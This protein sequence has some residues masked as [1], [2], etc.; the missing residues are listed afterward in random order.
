MASWYGP[1]LRGND[2]ASGERFRPHRRT[3]AHPSLPFDTVVVVARVD[4]GERV[5]VRIN[6]RGPYVEGRIIDL[7]KGAARRL[8]MLDD[9]VVRVEVRVRRRP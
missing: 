1:G 2:T 4:T 9:G 5:R 6:D 8:H 3:A 7:S